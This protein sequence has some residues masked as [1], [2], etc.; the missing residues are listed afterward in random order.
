MRFPT[1]GLWGFAHRNVQDAVAV[2]T[3]HLP[4]LEVGLVA[5][6]LSESDIAIVSRVKGGVVRDELEANVGEKCPTMIPLARRD[7]GAQHLVK[8]G[9]VPSS[10]DVPGRVTW[11]VPGGATFFSASSCSSVFVEVLGV[12]MLFARQR[13]V[14]CVYL[15]S[16]RP[17]TSSCTYIPSREGV[18]LAVV[19]R[20]RNLRHTSRLL[21]ADGAGSSGSSRQVHVCVRVPHGVGQDSPGGSV[22]LFLRLSPPELELNVV[23]VAEDER[24]ARARWGVG[25]R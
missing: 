22:M 10:A 15:Q 23:R 19:V 5:D 6:E 14:C 11:H 12:G 16:L 21:H 9:C 7:R 1:A 18:L 17:V 24:R 2:R 13:S 25:H 20:T 3:G 8:I 4:D